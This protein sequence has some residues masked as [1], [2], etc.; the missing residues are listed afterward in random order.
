M[1]GQVLGADLKCSE[2][3]RGSGLR[4]Q[5]FTSPPQCHLQAARSHSL[6]PPHAPTALASKGPGAVVDCETPYARALRE[7]LHGLTALMGCER[8]RATE[9]HALR[10][11]A[12]AAGAG[13][14]EDQLTL[15]L[16]QPAEHG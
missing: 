14:G 16:G 4:A 13:S 1:D 12:V 6:R 9:A 7:A 8:R 5:W 2:S 3:S 11:L 15:E 10:L